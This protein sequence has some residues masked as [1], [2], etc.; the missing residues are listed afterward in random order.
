MHNASSSSSGPGWKG[1]SIEGNAAPCLAYVD[2]IV[3]IPEE[4]RLES[5]LSGVDIVYVSG[6]CV[7]PVHLYASGAFTKY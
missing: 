4:M 5:A 3:A 7:R 2:S 1:S 6:L